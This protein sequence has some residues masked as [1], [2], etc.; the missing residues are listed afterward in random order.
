MYA[1]ATTTVTIFRGQQID[2]WG[3]PEDVNTVVAAGVPASITESKQYNK[4]EVTTQPRNIHYA[5][6]RMTQRNEDQ[7]YGVNEGQYL[8]VNDRVRD[9]KTGVTWT[10][11]GV[12]R[13]QNPAIRQ[14]IRADLQHVE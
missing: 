12:N 2:E 5:K 8:R 11:I 10:I 1:R 6:L 7:T 14:D 13:M 4:G 3:D 9:D